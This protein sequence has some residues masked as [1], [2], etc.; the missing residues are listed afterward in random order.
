MTKYRKVADELESA[1]ERADTAEGSLVK[2][3][4]Q[5]SGQ[6]ADSRT[7]SRTMVSSIH[8]SVKQYSFATKTPIWPAAMFFNS[9]FISET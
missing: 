3:R 5:H 2:V 7:S 4:M 6:S 8:D 1:M 9:K